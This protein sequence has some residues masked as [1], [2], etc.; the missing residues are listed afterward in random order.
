MLKKFRI[1]RTRSAQ[2]LATTLATSLFGLSVLV[3][4]ISSVAQ[5]GL[6]IQS[7]QAALSS[8]QQ[9]I[10]QDASKTVSSFVEEKFTRLETAVEFVDPV[11]AASEVRNTFMESLLGINPAFR[12]FLLVDGQSRQ[13]AKVSR[14]SESLSPQ[15]VGELGPD[16]LTQTSK[17]QRFI[18]PI[19]IDDVTSE[20][21]ITIAIPVKNSLGDF[22]GTLLA[23][24]N[25]KFMWDL[26]D[27]LKVGQTGLAYVVDKQGN[28]IA[29]RDTSR[30]LQGENLKNLPEVKKFMQS[31]NTNDSNPATLETGILGTQA[32]NT[33]SSLGSPNWAVIVE[34]PWQE[35]YQSVI[36]ATAASVGIILVLAVLAGLVGV[37]LARRLAVPLVDLTKTATRIAA[38]EMELQATPGGVQ[39]VA[40]LATAFNSMT[41]QLRDLIGTL[42]QRVT[43]RTKAL[44]TSADVSRRLST[45]MDQQQL[46]VE[47]VEQV[48]SAFNYYHVHIYLLN[49]ASGDLIMAGGTGEAGRLMMASGHKIPKSR[50]LV[51][52]AA[53]TNTA[54]LVPDTSVEPQW[55]PNPLLS[56]TKSEAAIPITLGDQVLGVLDV[57]HNVKDGLKQEDVDLLQSIA[58][59][60]AVA[61]QN[62][63]S[64]TDVQKRGER[65][66]LKTSI[67]QKIQSATT[68]EDALQVTAR[69]LGR[70]LGAKDIRVIL[71]AP[72]W[73][74][75]Q[76]KQ[77]KQTEESAESA[78]NNFKESERLNSANHQFA[79][80]HTKNEALQTAAH[81]LESSAYPAL[82]LSVD[83]NH[84]EVAGL[85]DATA[86]E[87]L[88]IHRAVN[89]LETGWDEVKN[90]LTGDPV[91]VEPSTTT[92]VGQRSTFILPSPLSDFARQMGYQSVAFLPITSGN[93]LVGIIAIGS[94][95]QIL[96][97]E[98]L[99]P[100]THI[101]DLLRTTL[102]KIL[103]VEEKKT[104]PSE[105]EALAFINPN[106][107]D[108]SKRNNHKDMLS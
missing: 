2:S 108:P 92:D 64:Y 66:A 75:S 59:Q 53:S 18:S 16:V 100:Y 86:Q 105:Q 7:Q 101:V 67:N 51:G 24:V 62:A 74:S 98:M 68:V 57:Q 3:L 82:V 95:K 107:N 9:S 65:E 80:A 12:E 42:E 93:K 63:R 94:I 89:D 35:A 5:I 27:Q 99:Q 88:Q 19:Y 41:A 90:L 87:I 104:P 33:Y 47:V 39:E 58:N 103:K 78:Q 30:V 22:Q 8:R 17:G 72:G 76:E 28:L 46:V 49:E 52:R 45:I 38:G 20:P 106:E 60:V 48:K 97:G 55:L 61:V 73:V 34:L 70:T 71:H 4:L 102:D 91:V 15:F 29:Y 81:I 13:L 6:N 54:V 83:D 79:A 43:V 32:V 25:L 14:I 23:E 77:G 37:Y 84:L 36:Q 69:E 31:S 96:T 44:A 11:T 21:L 40:G 10:A 85:T 1:N 50:G 26:V 56:E